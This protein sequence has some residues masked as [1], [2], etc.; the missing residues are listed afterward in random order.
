MALHVS[1]LAL[2]QLTLVHVQQA[3]V[4]QTVKYV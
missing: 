1:L 4:E 2:A 3:I